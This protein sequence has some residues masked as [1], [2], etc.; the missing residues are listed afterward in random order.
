MRRESDLGN[1]PDA[2][3]VSAYA[4]RPIRWAV[5]EGLITGNPVDGVETISP[6]GSASRAQ[7]AT[8]LMRFVRN[9]L[10]ID[11]LSSGQ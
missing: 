9:C 10:G 7:V 3:K 5:A 2:N 11:P 6:R 8:M 1:F 4:L